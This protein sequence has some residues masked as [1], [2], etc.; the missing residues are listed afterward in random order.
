MSETANTCNDESVTLT[1]T[2]H[3]KDHST[4]GSD[5]RLHFEATI[6]DAS[7]KGV[8]LITG[9]R[10]VES[11]TQTETTNFSSDGAPSETTVTMTSNLTRLGED[12][13]ADDLRSHLVLHMTYNANGVPTAS[14]DDSRIDCR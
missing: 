11:S 13:T 8:A 6:S 3:V 2:M 1:G 10:Y 14:T 4:L 7:V 12:G 9:A 5:G